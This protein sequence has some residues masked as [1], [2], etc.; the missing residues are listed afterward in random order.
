MLI[1]N[2]MHDD[3]SYL[4]QRIAR[5]GGLCAQEAVDS[6]LLNAI[7]RRVRAETY[8]IPRMMAKLL[9]GDALGLARHPQK[10]ETR[11]VVS[12]RGK[13]C[14]ATGRAG[15]HERRDRDKLATR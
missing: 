3:A 8:V 11:G 15:P 9:K 1:L 6:E 14:A 5:R 4:R 12:K 10:Q 7:R 2:Q 13:R